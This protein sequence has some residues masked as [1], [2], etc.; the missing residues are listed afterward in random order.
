[1]E[2]PERESVIVRAGQ[3]VRVSVENDTNVYG[4]VLARIAPAIRESSRMLLV[5]ADVPNKGGLHSGLFASGEIVINERE[6]VVSV[7]E[8]ALINFAGLEKVVTVNDSKAT[9]K[10]VVTGRHA[11]GLVEITSG[12]SAG[13]TVVINPAG[14]RTGQALVVVNKPEIRTATNASPAQQSSLP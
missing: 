13:E 7:P 12:L 8:S 11:G 9:E 4:G 1:L 14:I 3:A 10:T 5:E 6:E 2:V